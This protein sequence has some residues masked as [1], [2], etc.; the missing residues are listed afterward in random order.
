[1]LTKTKNLFELLISILSIEI[2]TIDKYSINLYQLILT[3][4]L[5]IIGSFVINLLLKK[6][7]QWK[8]LVELDDDIKSI[9]II[10]MIRLILYLLLILISIRLLGF[11]ITIFR[12]IWKLGLFSIGKNTIRLGSLIIGIFFFFFAFH[13]NK[14]FKPKT[15]KYIDKILDLDYST[16]KTVFSMTQYF[17]SF[18]IFF[19]SLTIIG[20]PLTAFTVIGGT[21]AIGVGLGSQNLINNFISGFVLMGERTTKIGDIIEIGD[22]IGTVEKI[23]FRSTVI[24]TFSNLRLIIPNS[25]LLENNVINWSLTDE[26]L[27]RKITIGVAYGSDVEEVLQLL[28]NCTKS[29]DTI[30][31][32]PEPFVIFSDFGDNALIF[33][34]YIY[35]NMKSGKSIMKIE[36]ELRILIYKS[37]NE[38]EIG[39]PFPQ[40][41]LYFHPT[42]PIDINIRKQDESE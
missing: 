30:N 15:E 41:D 6:I 39:I 24:K 2:F 18:I 31:S 13:I 33:D 7:K 21:L 12:Q 14:I 32:T 28:I 17:Y 11:P 27:R 26:I 34:I 19:F 5:F 35:L 29:L 38:A 23:G 36:S 20:I 8:F 25:S 9:P 4:L 16:H 3:I 22:N 37:L 40:Q 42:K 10:R 1:M